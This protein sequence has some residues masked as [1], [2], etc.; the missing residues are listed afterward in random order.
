MQVLPVLDLLDG[1]A[2]HA[3]AGKRATYAPV[4]SKLTSSSRPIDLARAMRQR[5]ELD[6][7]YIA[8]L[9]ALQHR[10]G[11]AL[12]IYAELA[13]DG[14]KLVLDAAVRHR[15]RALE[16]TE[17]GVSEIIVAL[18]T[19]ENPNDIDD[20][21]EAI[22]RDRTVF[23]VDLQG[24][25]PLGGP[26]A[27]QSLTPFEI[28]ERVVECGVTRL[29]LLD[30]AAVGTSG[31]W[32]LRP[33]AERTLSEF[34]AVSLISGG[35]VRGPDDLEDLRDAGVSAALVATALHTESIGLDDLR[36]VCEREASPE[37]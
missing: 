21:L 12:S 18:E 30:L 3:V 22:G 9:D 29:L 14:F 5:L 35:G 25:K 36:R 4:K 24:G 26:S 1:H 20:V 8:D 13:A 34:G 16:L 6:H 33:L 23:S 32:P 28:V 2:V 15:D 7:F 17:S 37:N 11:P 10:S 31:G 19:L 27:W